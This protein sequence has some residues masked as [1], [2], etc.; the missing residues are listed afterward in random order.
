M[1][2]ERGQ[3]VIRSAPAMKPDG[4]GYGPYELS[5]EL[6]EDESIAMTPDMLRQ[7][8]VAVLSAVATVEWEE[9]FVK[10]IGPAVE[11]KDDLIGTLIME[12]RSTYGPIDWPTKLNLV[13]SL[14][15]MSKKGF[16]T[17]RYGDDAVGQWDPE[18]ARQHGSVCI[19]AV[20]A[21]ERDNAALGVLT[22][23]FGLEE[24]VA[25]A[26]IGSMAST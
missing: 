25:R 24:E 12:M 13:P 9:R 7:H 22:E 1:T 20:V 2:D 8:A 5:M 4:S 16:L 21:V 11:N 26:I 6:S 14:G 23:A 15:I 19:E 18:D 10:T 3:V 17:V